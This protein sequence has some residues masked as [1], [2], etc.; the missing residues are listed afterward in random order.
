MIDWV[1]GNLDRAHTVDNL[2]SRALMSRRTF[3]RQFRQLIGMS[4]VEWLHA[5]R[6]ALTQRLLERS[7]H[8]IDAISALVGFGSPES[9]RLHFRRAFGVSPITWRATFKG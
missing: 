2:A 9:L 4:V 7:D 3:T 1:R 5:E 6:L 8:S